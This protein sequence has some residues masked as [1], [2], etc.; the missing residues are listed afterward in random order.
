[1]PIE[2]EY[3]PGT[4]DLARDQ[5]ERIESS[6]GTKGLTMSGAPCVV[7]WTRGRRSGA[8]RKAPLI[9]VEHEGTYAAV[10]SLGGAPKHPVWY[11]N[12]TADPEV[13]VQDGTEV[14]DYLAREVTGDEKAQWWA[15]ATE[16]WPSYDQYQAKT[17]R[18]IPVVLLEP[19]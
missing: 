5:V 8:V 11:L 1:M 6:G 18:I 9:R 3:I 10:A 2:G 16:V 7:L 15:R 12:L 14:R 13:T 4:W 19:R 17:D